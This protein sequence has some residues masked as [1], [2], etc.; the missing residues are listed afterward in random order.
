MVAPL[1]TLT[2]VRTPQRRAQSAAATVD[3]TNLSI[4]TDVRPSAASEG[5]RAARW[6]VARH[7]GSRRGRM[8]TAGHASACIAVAA[9]HSRRVSGR[10]A[11]AGCCGVAAHCVRTGRRV[12]TARRIRARRRCTA[13][14]GMRRRGTA[15]GRGVMRRCGTARGRG[16][17]RRRRVVRRRAGVCR[18]TRFAFILVLPERKNWNCN[19]QHQHGKLQQWFFSFG[20]AIHRGPPGHPKAFPC[21]GGKPPI[22]IE[23]PLTFNPE[24]R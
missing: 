18:S 3:G 7:T 19:R 1:C 22:N 15:G 9:A 13:S 16:G 23:P 17:M 24:V 4:G 6:G 8:P 10:G 14:R 5:N 21:L 11:P 20:N 12:G 2:T